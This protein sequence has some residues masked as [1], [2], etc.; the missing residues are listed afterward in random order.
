MAVAD[1]IELC[2]HGSMD[3]EG[4][5][6]LDDLRRTSRSSGLAGWAARTSDLTS[7][8]LSGFVW[9]DGG[10]IVGN[11]S[12]IPFY[13][14]G[15]RIQLIANVAVHPDYRRRGIA[16]Q[17]TRRALQAAHE[18]SSQEIWLHVRD[19]NLGAIALYEELGWQQKVRRTSW[20]VQADQ[21]VEPPAQGMQ[22]LNRPASDW[23]RLSEWFERAYPQA[24]RW[25]H[26]T[27]W[28][29]FRP[30]LWRSFQRFLGDL[31]LREWSAYHD[32]R[33]E[34]ALIAELHPGRGVHLWAAIPPGGDGALQ[35]LLLQA[36]SV[37]SPRLNIYFEFP[38]EEGAEAIQ[39]AGFSPNRTL[40]WMK[41]E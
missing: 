36:R 6:F 11:V 38:A 20:R 24:I 41:A 2:F 5:S 19:D 7:M 31:S 17:L 1:L 23:G 39:R 25:Y 8:P 29:A 21:P 3:A 15:R 30:G 37:V 35:A 26:R 18:R 12:L 10:R 33:L 9:E 40:I 14:H 16:R 28:E 32:G 27:Y 22:V 13:Q 34:G 4:R